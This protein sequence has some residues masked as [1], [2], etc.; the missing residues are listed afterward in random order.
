M[1]LDG[2]FEFLDDEGWI[3]F[4]KGEVR[5][6]LRGTYHAFRNSGTT[7]GRMM[8]ITNA[9]GL[10]GYFELISPLAVPRDMDRLNE[11][12]EHYGYVF[13]PPAGAW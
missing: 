8:F 9:G 4:R 1:V 6:S 11:I 5:C 13:L 2:D 12:S 10:D 3:P 7:D